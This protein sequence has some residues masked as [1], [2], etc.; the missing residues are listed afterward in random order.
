MSAMPM[1]IEEPYCLA[2][3][4][5][6]QANLRSKLSCKAA[7]VAKT[8]RALRGTDKMSAMH[9]ECCRLFVPDWLTIDYLMDAS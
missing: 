1:R 2:A 5:S 7:A 8:A 4:L 3:Q 6:V 9:N